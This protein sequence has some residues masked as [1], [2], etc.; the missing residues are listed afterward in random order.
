[1]FCFNLLLFGL[2]RNVLLCLRQFPDQIKLLCFVP[3][4]L[5]QK[6]NALL[7]EIFFWYQIK[8]F[9]FRSDSKRTK[10]K[11]FA[12]VPLISFDIE[13]F[14]L[15]FRY[16]WITSL[17]AQV[18]EHSFWLVDFFFLLAIGWLI[19]RFAVQSCCPG[20]GSFLSLV[21]CLLFPVSSLFGWLIDRFAVRSCCPGDGTFISSVVCLLFPVTLLIGWL[22]DWFGGA[23]LPPGDGTFLFL[24]GCLVRFPCP[25]VW[26][27]DWL[28]V[29]SCCPVD[30]S[31]P[32]SV[33]CLQWW[34]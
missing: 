23:V 19:Y 28:A 34:A 9:C 33:G 1:M 27:I 17:A 30:G 6:G 7:A 18:L 10:S 5:G 25:L 20:E 4:F 14:V 24:G 32:S 22:I 3:E 21:G 26:L 16:R 12:F 31:F 11:C 15:S 29:R 8:M 2:N 13:T